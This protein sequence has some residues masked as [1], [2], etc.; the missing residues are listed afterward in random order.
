MKSMIARAVATLAVAVS[1]SACGSDETVTVAPPI[2]TPAPAPTPTTGTLDVGKC[3]AQVVFPDGTTVQN[4]VIPDV[5]T[6]NPSLPAGFPNGRKPADPVIDITLAAILLDIDADG[7][8]A[9]TFAG[10]PLNPPANDV[11]FPSG[12]PFLAPPQG[13]PRISATSGTT[14]NFRTAPDTAYERVD[15]MGFPALS[16]ALVPSA[17]KIPYNDASPVNDANGEFAGPIVETLTAITMA[18]Q[19]DLNRAELNLCAD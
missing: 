11:A 13:N 15:R 6:I 4:L 1:L 17:L 16:T 14:F 9:A 5:L 10:I 3:L 7:Q 8:S 19:D 18:L 2:D 12:F